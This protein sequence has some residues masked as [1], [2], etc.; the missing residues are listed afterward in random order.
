[1]QTFKIT[2]SKGNTKLGD[3]PSFSLS[4]LTTCPGKS[5]WCSK[6]C[7]A[8]K[9]EHQ[10][11]NVNKSYYNNYQA[12]FEPSFVDSMDKEIKNLI[13]KGKKVFR[14]HVGGDYFSTEY[15]EKWYKIILNNPQMKF[16]SYTRSLIN[17]ELLTSL[18]HLKQLPNITL[19]ASIDSSMTQKPPVNWRVAMAGDTNN[20]NIPKTVFCLE[21]NNKVTSCSKCKLCFN[22]NSN[23]NIYFETH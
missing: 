21:Q 12:T 16:Y 6:N 9:L 1:M 7:Y 8:F 23:V 17:D 22:N 14:I 3:I 4:S 18:E 19:F 11:P 5:Q 13:K 15:I 20:F 2:I 10:Y